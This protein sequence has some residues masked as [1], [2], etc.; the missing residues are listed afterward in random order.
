MSDIEMSDLAKILSGAAR[1]SPHGETELRAYPTTFR[2][3]LAAAIVGDS[4]N[5]NRV[6]YASKFLG[7]SGIRHSGPSV[8]D[9]IPYAGNAVGLQEN[10]QNRNYKGA[11]LNTLG[12]APMLGGLKKL[13][14]GAPVS[15]VT[16]VAPQLVN[17]A[18][19]GIDHYLIRN[20]PELDD[21]DY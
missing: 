8:I 19:N 7:S 9:F 2:D 3:N 14:T 12:L 21:E 20:Q 11:A 4:P 5:R 17:G 6:D 15:S 13:I 16:S 18:A 1:Y 10:L